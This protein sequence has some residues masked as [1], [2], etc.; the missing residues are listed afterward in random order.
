MDANV[1]TEQGVAYINGEFT[2]LAEARVPVLDRGFIFGDGV[3]EVI[4]I[5]SRQPFRVL[6]YEEYLD[7]LCEFV[8]RLDPDIVIERMFGEAPFGLLVAPTWRR[9][10][11]DLVSDVKRVFEERNVRQGVRRGI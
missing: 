3:Y 7:L 10:K 5:Y 4:P 6:G 9:N 1:P 8:E 2:P 11:N